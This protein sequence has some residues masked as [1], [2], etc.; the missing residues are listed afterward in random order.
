MGCAVNPA[1]TRFTRDGSGAVS[2]TDA[3]RV[4]AAALRTYTPLAVL[5]CYASRRLLPGPEEGRP[6]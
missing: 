4:S 3:G 2:F 1:L 6:P 5:T